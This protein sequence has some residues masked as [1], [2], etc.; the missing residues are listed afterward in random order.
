MSYVI[1]TER[2]GL[3]NW[4]ESDLDEFAAMNANSE[5]MRFF[6]KAL[7]KE[8]SLFL[9]KRLRDHFHTHGYTYFLAEKLQTKEFLGFIGLAYQTYDTPYNPFVDIGWRLKR[10]AWGK[11][12]ATE[13][14][15]ACLDF[16]F[17]TLNLPEVYSV[18]PVPNK[19]SEKIMQ[20]I[21]MQKVEEFEHPEVT[22][23]HFL[24][25]CVLYRKE[26]SG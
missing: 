24:K 25:T 20:K 2:I 11:G 12:Y 17:D 1:Q 6:E 22:E 18:T 26:K 5:V 19:P 16:A 8:E 23:G 4:Q 21:G 14:A 10:A 13:G 3:R 9:L 7:K 15:K